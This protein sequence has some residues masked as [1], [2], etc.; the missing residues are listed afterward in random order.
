MKKILALLLCAFFILSVFSFAAC[1]GSEKETEAN[2]TAGGSGA[3]TELLTDEEGNLLDGIP[4]GKYDFN[5]Y[6]YS[7]AWGYQILEIYNDKIRTY[8]VKVDNL[9]VATNGV[10]E[11]KETVHNDIEIP[12]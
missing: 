3:F 9:Y 2:G 5:I 12:L 10:F 8:H 7:I 6:D 4:D 1:G 11:V